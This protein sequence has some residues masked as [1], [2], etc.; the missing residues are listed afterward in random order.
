MKSKKILLILLIA[1]MLIASNMN[2]VYADNTFR[3]NMATDKQNYAA[4]QYVEVTVSVS[5]PNS[6][7]IYGVRGLLTYDQDVFEKIPT[8]T[9]G[10]GLVI[11]DDIISLN[12][13]G[14][15]VYNNNEGLFAIDAPTTI[16]PGGTQSI[17]KIRLK[18]KEG[19][20]LGKADIMLSELTGTTMDAS[21]GDLAD[22]TAMPTQISVNIMDASEIGGGEIPPVGEPTPSPVPASPSPSPKPIVTPS[23]STSGKLPQTGLSNWIVP[24]IGGAV[25][26]SL[27]A[28]VAYARYKDI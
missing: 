26:I 2:F 23:A 7:G 6:T 13:W 9:T 14:T 12:G 3:V 5:D 1:V 16:E 11:S 24:V 8:K 18:V 17:M 21:I 27:V 4:G 20:K 25:I 10:I 19:A 15:V 28:F 22:A